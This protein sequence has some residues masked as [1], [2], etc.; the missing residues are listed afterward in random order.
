MLDL[1]IGHEAMAHGVETPFFAFSERKLR[2]SFREL[3]DPI[4]RVHPR[5][6]IAWSYKTNYLEPVCVALHDLGAHAEIM[7]AF[8]LDLVERRC[9]AMPRLFFNGL[10]KSEGILQR[11]VRQGGYIHCL[12]LEDLKQVERA[13]VACL[14]PAKVAL[15]LVFADLAES[16]WERFGF[17]AGGRALDDALSYVATSPWLE[18]DGLHAHLGTFLDDPTLYGRLTQSLRST[19]REIEARTGR[20]LSYL[21]IGGGLASANTPRYKA[22]APGGTPTLAAYGETIAEAARGMNPDTELI[23]ESAR[24]LVDPAGSLWTTVVR[25]D[26]TKGGQT[27]WVDSGI[28]QLYTALSFFHGVD[29]ATLDRPAAAGTVT[30]RI[31]GSLPM[32]ADVLAERAA[33]PALR[34]GDILR[35]RDAGAY[36]VSMGMTFT[37]GRPAVVWHGVDGSLAVVRRTETV[38]D[39]QRAERRVPLRAHAEAAKA[40]PSSHAPSE[41][42]R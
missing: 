5:T 34:V 38:D 16:E 30:T 39:V 2:D 10:V 23:I 31:L 9:P 11:L 7:S 19:S 26:K 8:E 24:A 37:A 18:L 35:F 4:R 6:N 41:A 15:R 27:A 13:A 17:A 1:H 28:H 36:N 20:P 33:L 42:Q 22:P 25:V 12:C 29:A 32:N 14:R 3:M 40:M 21:D